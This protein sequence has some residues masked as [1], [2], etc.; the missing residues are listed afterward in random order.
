MTSPTPEELAA[1]LA[2]IEAELI[3]VRAERDLYKSS[4]YLHLNRHDPYRT[5]TPEEVQEMISAPRG[6]SLRDIVA[7]FERKL[8]DR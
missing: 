6:E 3:R 4:A 5:P 1:R 2:A 7:E 8:A